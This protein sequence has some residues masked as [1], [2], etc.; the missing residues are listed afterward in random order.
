MGTDEIGDFDDEM[1][2]EK[3]LRKQGLKKKLL[4]EGEGW[5]TPEV[6]D[7]VEANKY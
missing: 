7:E 1:G 3:E 2:E 6:G 5:E 4:K